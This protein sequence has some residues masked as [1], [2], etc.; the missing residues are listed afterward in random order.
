[1]SRAAKGALTAPLEGRVIAVT[2]ADDGDDPLTRQLE[3][4]G[5]TV[6]AWPTLAFEP[7]ADPAPLDA[8][9][10]DPTAWDWIVFTSARAVGPVT[11]RVRAP[12]GGPWPRVAAVGA[13]T[14]RALEAAG[15]A[16]NVVGEAGADAL[17]AR[18]A[19]EAALEGARVLFPAASRARDALAVAL[20][21]AGAFVTRV[22][23][24]R[25]VLRP[26]DGA[27]VGADL[28]AGVDAVAFASPSA[29]EALAPALRQ[30]ALDRWRRTVLVAIGPTTA[31]AVGEQPGWPRPIV[32]DDT[33]FEGMVRAL[34]SAFAEADP[35]TCP[36]RDT[37]TPLD[38]NRP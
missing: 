34:A 1:M 31:A 36:N 21:A 6:L 38:T 5:A 2:R 19:D 3:A 18:L 32:A 4:S 16:P 24:Y 27:Q 22:E 28:E 10:A 13:A 8:A 7:P 12:G 37:R 20:E 17:A 9:L 29:V 26:P 33:S 25:T 23:A 30:I 35:P 15:W 14:A 11:N